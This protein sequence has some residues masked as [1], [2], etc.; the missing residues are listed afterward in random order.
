MCLCV[1]LC[2]V[3][4]HL[5][6][7]VSAVSVQSQLGGVCVG[8]GVCVGSVCIVCVKCVCVRQRQGRVWG[9][10][11]SQRVLPAEL[12]GRAGM[13]RAEQCRGRRRHSDGQVRGG[14]GQALRGRV[15]QV[16]RLLVLG[17]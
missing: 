3:W 14:Q 15:T 17:R 9:R 7:V 13:Q 5:A 8:L 2:A 12:L 1:C 11:G 6:P 10:F 16:H 4:S